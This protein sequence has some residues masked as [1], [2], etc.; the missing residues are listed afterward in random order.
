MMQR[1]DSLALL[2]IE[3]LRADEVLHKCIP[4]PLFSRANTQVL[5]LC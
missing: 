4:K 3:G 2:E 5:M 1:K